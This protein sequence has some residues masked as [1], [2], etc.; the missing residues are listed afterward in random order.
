MSMKMEFYSFVFL[1]FILFVGLTGRKGRKRGLCI[2]KWAIQPCQLRWTS[3][4]SQLHR[5]SPE[6]SAG[7]ESQ[8]LGILLPQLCPPAPLPLPA[9]PRS[10][11]SGQ[12]FQLYLCP[13]ASCFLSEGDFNSYFKRKIEALPP[14]YLSTLPPLHYGLKYA[15]HDL[16]NLY[17]HI[18][19]LIKM[20]LWPPNQPSHYAC[21]HVGTGTGGRKISR[22]APC[23]L[24][25][26]AKVKVTLCH[27]RWLSYYKQV[28]SCCLF[29]PMFFTVL[30]FLLVIS[31]LK[32]APKQSAEGLFSI[33]ECEK[34]AICL[35]DVCVTQASFR[36]QSYGPWVQG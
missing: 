19:L 21:S 11:S 32:M 20:Y 3:P 34:A 28:S 7:V 4:G 16:H 9:Q 15:P 6:G 1:V 5:V 22:V 24:V 14:W 33:P 8:N 30:C 17:S 23:S 29:S 18:F 13:Q 10:P 27:L 36:L 2:F 12:L 25:F 35:M 26:P 31:L